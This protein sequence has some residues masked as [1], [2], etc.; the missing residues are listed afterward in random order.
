MKF[1]F[2]LISLI[3]GTPL[4]SQVLVQNFQN[5]P[6]FGESPQAITRSTG[7]G[8]YGFDSEEG[9]FNPTDSN[10][11]SEFLVGISSLM[12]IDGG[13]YRTNRA[14]ESRSYSTNI[15]NNSFDLF[16]KY[17]HKEYNFH[18]NYF[19]NLYLHQ[20]GQNGFDALLFFKTYDGPLS[21]LGI[22]PEYQISNNVLQFA[23][24]RKI[25]KFTIAGGFLTNHY[26]YKI[27][28][29]DP[30]SVELKTSFLENFQLLLSLNYEFKNFLRFYLL[31][32]TASSEIEL[33]P[34]INPNLSQIIREYKL[35]VSFPGL[36]AYGVQYNILDD[37]K[38]SLEMCHDWLPY[39]DDPNLF[40]RWHQELFT[41]EIILGVNYN[42][43]DSWKIG[44]MYSTFLEYSSG[45]RLEHH[46]AYQGAEFFP[47]DKLR[48]YKAATSYKY[49]DWSVQLNYQYGVSEYNIYDDGIVE[50]KS[51]FLRLGI[52]TNF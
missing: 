5:D 2:L 23:V 12:N 15:F 20:Q 3:L 46:V 34:N 13:T 48:M 16:L 1:P 10:S 32:R 35:L 4:F 17:K 6:F 38:L 40:V 52:K 14:N 7:I 8:N 50:E 27:I 44:A 24:S 19:T 18:L 43:F 29:D 26:I 51:Q 11:K 41:S 45:V 42:I 31:G 49:K 37:L 25:G 22:N 39:N 30:Y 28:L 47:L 9:F 36:V 21:I 33:I